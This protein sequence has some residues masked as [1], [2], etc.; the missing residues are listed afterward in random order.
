MTEGEVLEL[1]RMYLPAERLPAVL[2]A[3]GY[4][5]SPSSLLSDLSYHLDVNVPWHFQVEANSPEEAVELV[6]RTVKKRQHLFGEYGDV[7]GSQQG[8]IDIVSTVHLPFMTE[9]DDA[10]EGLLGNL[11][12]L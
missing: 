6:R 5:T 7:R 1:L 2:E 4:P 10:A 3:L 12:L 8:E 9:G 11:G